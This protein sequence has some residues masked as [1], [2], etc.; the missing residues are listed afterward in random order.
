MIYFKGNWDDHLPLIEFA[1]KN[2]YH[3]SIG[4]A[5]L[6]TFMVGGVGPRLDGLKWVILLFLPKIVYDTTEKI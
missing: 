5:L 1:Y 2:S 3:A 6:K 4:M